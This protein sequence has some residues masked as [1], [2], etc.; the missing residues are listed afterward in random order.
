MCLF[1][2]SLLCGERCL[3]LDSRAQAAFHRTG[4]IDLLMNIARNWV[5]DAETITK[6]SFF[7]AHWKGREKPFF[8]SFI[9]HNSIPSPLLS[10]L[11]LLLLLHF[12]FMCYFKIKKD[13][14]ISQSLHAQ[15][16]IL[17]F[18]CVSTY[19]CRFVRKST[20]NC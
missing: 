6:A 17:V 3:S 11:S 19:F 16:N 12:P 20:T 18:G 9:L 14:T 15:H 4:G 7:K 5:N 8:S 2:F 13:F 10:S 1:N